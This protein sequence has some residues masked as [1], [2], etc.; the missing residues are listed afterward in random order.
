MQKRKVGIIGHFGGNENILD[1]QTIKTRILHDELKA[2]T[3]WTLFTVDTYYKNKNL[4]KLIADTLKCLISAK[5]II[6]LLSRNGMNFYF[7]F[8]YLWKNVFHIRVYHDVIGGNLD[9]YVTKNPRFIKYLNSFVVNW[10]ETDSLRVK[11][12]KL[13][14]ENCKVIP[15][16][17]RLNVIETKTVQYE[18][19]GIFRFCI[20]SRIM[21][22][23]GVEIAIEA[24]EQI[25]KTAQKEICQLDLYGRIDEQYKER[26]Q[27]IMKQ[28]SESI[29]YKGE[30]P[31]T[32]SVETIKK[33]Y[34]LLFPTYWEGEG[35]PG[36]I[37]DA[38]SAGIP[39]IA[40]DWNCNSEIVEN[41]V[42]GIL[43]PNDEMENLQSAIVWL[44]TNEDQRQRM[45]NNC[46][47]CAKKYHPDIYIKKMVELIVNRGEML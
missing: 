2:T 43:Y 19:D 31:Y 9:K 32:K 30:I 25:N 18:Y 1:G 35:F 33:Y 42:N 41:K 10:V 8:L 4:L 36:T 39:V 24:I 22:E 28:T 20:F 46:V 34:A 14:I 40:T 38:F 44:I 27:S 6:I 13:G 12:E 23:K 3:D 5:D 21:K 17:K 47:L 29:A 16:F 15:N 11:L 45:G 26:F 37:I 7:P